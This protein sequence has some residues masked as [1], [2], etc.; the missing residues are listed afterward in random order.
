[1][2]VQHIQDMPGV[3]TKTHVVNTD[4]DEVKTP[5]V[6]SFFNYLSKNH[7]SMHIF[8]DWVQN[9]ARLTNSGKLYVHVVDREHRPKFLNFDVSD[10]QNFGGW[11]SIHNFTI[12]FG[13]DALEHLLLKSREVFG[14]ITKDDHL[15]ILP[16]Y[17]HSLMNQNRKGNIFHVTQNTK[18]TSFED[19][20]SCDLMFV[21]LFSFELQTYITNQ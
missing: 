13:R 19:W 20:R 9:S 15:V 12:A 1:M 21:E 8:K 10:I 4:I 2:G 11:L 3:D 5:V 18:E 6:P 16:I 17:Y 7:M 14:V